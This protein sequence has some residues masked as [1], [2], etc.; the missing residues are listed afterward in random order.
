[1]QPSAHAP[2]HAPRLLIVDDDIDH[3]EILA[4]LLHRRGY[5]IAV[6]LSGE[7]AIALAR[8]LRPDLILLDLYMPKVDGFSTAEHL[9]GHPET[10]NVPIV[11]LSACG[12]PATATRAIEAG[13]LEYLAKPFHAAELIAVVERSLGITPPRC[14]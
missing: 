6:A 3:A 12:E 1:M 5:G 13:A 8:L 7:H 14:H 2:T 9:Q 11:L 10:R 4:G